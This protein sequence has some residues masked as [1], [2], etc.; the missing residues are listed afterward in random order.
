MLKPIV[1][2]IENNAQPPFIAAEPYNKHG[3]FSSVL[4][5][6]WTQVL[7]EREAGELQ[8]IYEAENPALSR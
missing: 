5:R 7:P 6:P 3:G 8:R 2:H 1:N 4:V